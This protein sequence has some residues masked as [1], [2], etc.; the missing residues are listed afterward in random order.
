VAP[1]FFL[2]WNVATRPI[3]LAKKIF[4]KNFLEIFFAG[5]LNFIRNHFL[6]HRQAVAPLSSHI[7]E[8]RHVF[9][10]KNLLLILCD[11][12]KALAILSLAESSHLFL[13]ASRLS[14]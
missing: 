12:F 10:Q 3:F 11:S 13:I 6:L 8:A 4:E 9:W 5:L 1:L 2:T 14:Y 7:S